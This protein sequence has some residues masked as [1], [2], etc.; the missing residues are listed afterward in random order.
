MRVVFRDS[1]F[2]SEDGEDDITLELSVIPRE[3]ELVEFDREIIPDNLN[4]ILDLNTDVMVAKVESVM[5]IYSKTEH[6][7]EIEMNIQW[8]S[9]D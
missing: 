2:C 8:P 1:N 3:N 5:Y 4:L 7:I 6:F 9:I